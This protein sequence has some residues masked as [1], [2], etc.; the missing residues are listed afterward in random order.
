MSSIT[1]PRAGRTIGA[2][3]LLQVMGSPNASSG[4]DWKPS[5]TTANKLSPTAAFAFCF[6]VTQ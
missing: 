6:T 3:N 5:A 2:E 4:S 1:F